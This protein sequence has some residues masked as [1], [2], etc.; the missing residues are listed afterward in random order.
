M[1]KCFQYIKLDLFVGL[2]IPMASG[3]L[4]DKE[5]G[6]YTKKNGAL[7]LNTLNGCR[8][9]LYSTFATTFGYPI[10]LKSILCW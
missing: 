9:D 6:N 4:E 10:L 3:M 2:F 8:Q 7:G 1:L 5:E